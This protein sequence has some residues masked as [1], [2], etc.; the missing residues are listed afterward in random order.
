MAGVDVDRIQLA[1]NSQRT[2]R[3]YSGG[4][5]QMAALFRH[6]GHLAVSE[7]LEVALAQSTD[8]GLSGRDTF[9]RI[10]YILDTT[11]RHILALAQADAHIGIPHDLPLGA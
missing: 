4:E 8:A 9:S 3:L 7:T 5:C 2:V 6:I 11:R 10:A 1:P